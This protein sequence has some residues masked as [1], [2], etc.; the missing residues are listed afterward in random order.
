M[1][2]TVTV[3]VLAQLMEN[4][5]IREQIFERQ[6]FINIRDER[7]KKFTEERNKTSRHVL[8]HVYIFQQYMRNFFSFF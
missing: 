2:L 1:S 4:E 5:K 3:T 6:V 7:R 8:I